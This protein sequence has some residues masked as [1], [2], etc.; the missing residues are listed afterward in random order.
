MIISGGGKRHGRLNFFL[1]WWYPLSP[2]SHGS[3]LPRAPKLLSH[4]VHQVVRYYPRS[5]LC[6]LF[7]LSKSNFVKF[8]QVFSKIYQ[9]LQAE[10]NFNRIVTKYIF[11]LYIVISIFLL[12]TWSK[13]IRFDFSKKL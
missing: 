9:L 6:C 5:N 4:L 7:F 12:Y 3:K 2:L 13:F 8:D 10:I 1:M 11:I